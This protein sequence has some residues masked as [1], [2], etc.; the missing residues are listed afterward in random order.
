VKAAS[1]ANEVVPDRDGNMLM[2]Q[3]WAI[4][5]SRTDSSGKP[6]NF[7]SGAKLGPWPLPGKQE[8]DTWARSKG[9]QVGD[10]GYVVAPNGDIYVILMSQ[11]GLGRLDVYANDGTLKKQGLIE[12]I[13][14]GSS[15]LAVDAA[16]NIYLGVNIRPTQGP[17]FPFGFSAVVPENGWVWWKAKREGIWS[18]PY[19]NTYLYHWGSVMK[20]SPKGGRFYI[21]GGRI[22]A[23]RPDVPA[24]AT[25]YRNGYLNI[26]I[27]VQGSQGLF[28]GCGPIPTNGLNWGDP[29]CTCN[30]SRLAVDGFGRVF[31][32]DVFRFSVEMVDT[33][34]NAIARIGRYG[35]ADSKSAA[36]TDPA[37]VWPA[38]VS[39]ADDDVFVSDS[40]NRRIAQMKVKY[41][42]S[43]EC[44]LP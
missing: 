39:V 9:P 30:N 1:K 40:V 5:L 16:G 13:P 44:P 15:G 43:A 8:E 33:A 3:G 21:W 41:A 6:V 12:N 23:T 2:M 4:I 27:A 42:E 25:E 20:F 34:G 37:F 26:S 14:H 11:Y 17:L 36:G 32:P 24:D 31:M 22:A 18:Y 28:P 7:A 10:R 38:F 29:S 35:N 19:Y